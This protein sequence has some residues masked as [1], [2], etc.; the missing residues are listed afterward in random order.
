MAFTWTA[1]GSKG[2]VKAYA[3]RSVRALVSILVQEK[4][5]GWHCMDLPVGLCTMQVKNCKAS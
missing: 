2:Q 1:L 5:L 3:D 4:V